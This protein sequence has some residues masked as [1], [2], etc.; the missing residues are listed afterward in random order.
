MSDAEF[1]RLRAL[2]LRNALTNYDDHRRFAREEAGRRVDD[3]RD[4]VRGAK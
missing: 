3:V 2:A 4:Y 1:Y